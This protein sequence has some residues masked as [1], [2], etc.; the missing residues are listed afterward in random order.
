M[1]QTS[2]DHAVTRYQRVGEA[3]IDELQ[4]IYQSGGELKAVAS[5]L[6]LEEKRVIL[7]ET[8]DADQVMV[9]PTRVIASGEVDLGPMTD[10]KRAA[11]AELL[12][13]T[14][15]GLSRNAD[16]R[17]RELLEDVARSPTASPTL[18]YEPLYRDLA[19]VDLLAKDPTA[20]EW[21][22]RALAHNLHFFAGDDAVY[23]LTDLASGYLQLDELDT[24]L[25]MLARLIRHDP[26]N[27]MLYRF[28]ATGFPTL[29]LTE[30][31]LKGV[32]RGLDVLNAVVVADAEEEE[33]L[34]DELLMARVD[35]WASAKQ[36]READVS[37]QVLEELEAA[38]AM[39]LEAAEPL[40]PE[41]LCRTLVPDWNAI[42]VK[43]PLRFV[44]L[45]ESVQAL[46]TGE[47]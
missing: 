26:T 11:V 2:G 41:E 13:G 33:D 21:L 14:P 18:E 29:G 4:R 30:L 22:R 1:T 45:P 36:G 5:W 16:A 40:P 32:Q 23:Q 28:M 42:P 35:L 19:E 9:K 47:G 38:L 25:R 20:L 10:F 39:D 15:E 8:L 17:A 46:V 43:R 27:I 7:A 31:G 3:L 12:F 34:E 44:D 37:P 6:S 24:G